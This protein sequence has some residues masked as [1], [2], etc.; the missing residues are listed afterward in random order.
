[1]LHS[2]EEA[3][4]VRELPA[5][6][7]TRGKKNAIMEDRVF[8]ELPD[9]FCDTLQARASYTVKLD[10]SDFELALLKGL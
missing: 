7:H 9:D 5:R 2:G 4:P 6:S 8:H 1:M 3:G 10:D